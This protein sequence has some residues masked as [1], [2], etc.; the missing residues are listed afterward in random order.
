VDFTIICGSTT[1]VLGEPHVA[2]LGPGQSQNVIVKAVFTAQFPE[3]LTIPGNCNIFTEA[4]MYHKIA[5]TNETNNGN[6]KIL[7]F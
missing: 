4:D 2:P 3:W 6:T 7:T 1:M 5:E